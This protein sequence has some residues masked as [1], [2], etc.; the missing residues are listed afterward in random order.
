[1]NYAGARQEKIL[2]IGNNDEIK[3][4]IVAELNDKKNI[5]V[6]VGNEIFGSRENYNEDFISKIEK[7]IAKTLS[8]KT[9]EEYEGLRD[10]LDKLCGVM[11]AHF[12]SQYFEWKIGEEYSVEKVHSKVIAKHQKFLDYLLLVTSEDGYV[13]IENDR[14]KI[15]KEI[16]NPKID[17]GKIPKEYPSFSSFCLSTSVFRRNG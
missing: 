5:Q 7:H 11:A 15:L 9:V 12:L 17:A 6:I 8:V 4:N 3:K 10:K 13:A 16:D 14:I 1:M 2:I